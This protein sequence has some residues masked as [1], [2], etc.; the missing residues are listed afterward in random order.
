MSIH[1]SVRS[2]VL[3]VA[4]ILLGIS[5]GQ[6]N[7]DENGYVTPE[8]KAIQAWLSGVANNERSAFIA[9]CGG[10]A[11]SGLDGRIAS[12]KSVLIFPLGKNRGTYIFIQ[13]GRS[14]LN[15]GNVYYSHGHWQVSDLLGGLQ[16]QASHEELIKKLLKF[17]FRLIGPIGIDQILT[18]SSDINCP[19]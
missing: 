16:T 12:Y 14:V 9:D 15:S 5:S 2:V 1:S 8:T 18:K 7:G 19:K 10:D 6:A 11:P 4:L 3:A 13:N 17:P